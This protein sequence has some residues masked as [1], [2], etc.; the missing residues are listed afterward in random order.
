MSDLKMPSWSTTTFSL[1]SMEALQAQ[2]SANSAKHRCWKRHQVQSAA[3]AEGSQSVLQELQLRGGSGSIAGQVAVLGTARPQ[4]GLPYCCTNPGQLLQ[5]VWRVNM[6]AG[7][8]L[9]L[10]WRVRPS[11][12]HGV[13][14]STKATRL[15]QLLTL[16]CGQM[17]C[18]ERCQGCWQGAGRKWATGSHPLRWYTCSSGVSCAASINSSMASTPDEGECWG[19]TER[20]RLPKLVTLWKLC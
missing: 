7:P 14:V 1:Y 3:A 5:L 18:S 15:L 12:D 2:G 10:V 9:Q 4:A 8:V 20:Q 11:Q 17:R 13:L 16:L 6:P 19:L